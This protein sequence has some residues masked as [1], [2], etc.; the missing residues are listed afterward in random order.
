MTVL[1]TCLSADNT[2]ILT[3]LCCPR[4][5]KRL[6]TKAPN[7][8][9][10]HVSEPTSNRYTFKADDGEAPRHPCGCGGIGVH[11]VGTY[12]ECYNCW[13]A[14]KAYNVTMRGRLNQDNVAPAAPKPIRIQDFVGNPT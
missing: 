11:K 8:R 9:Y 4:C 3:T 7:P 12:W 5:L 2:Q 13:K 14:R 1:G 10:V 6:T